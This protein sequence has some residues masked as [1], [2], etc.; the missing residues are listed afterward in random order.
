MNRLN[1]IKQDLLIVSNKDKAKLLSRFFKTGPGQYGE[2]DVFAGIVVPDIRKVVKK[3][4]D[5]KL[6]DIVKLLHSREHEFRLTALL[7]LVYKYSKGSDEEKQKI[8][9]I[10][11]AN[12]KW[13]N[14]WDLVDL[15]APRIIGEHLVT[16]K[17][18]RSILIKLAKSSSLW[19]RRIAVLATFA[20]IKSGECKEVFK[21]SEML[22]KD[23]HDLIHKAV[24]W[25]LRELGKR[26]GRDV[27]ISFLEKHYKEMPRTM[28]RYSIE[29]FSEG[30]RGKYMNRD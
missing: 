23:E 16:N 15:S 9:D 25:M 8:Y 27:E 17:K 13:I 20:F 7:L 2:G 14:N 22:L 21:I 18:D 24:G 12:T 30:E 10:Y 6:S 29:H 11:L 5:M 1:S 26:C 28:L 4:R 3:H 19:E